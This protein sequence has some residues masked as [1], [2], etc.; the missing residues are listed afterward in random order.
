MTFIAVRTIDGST[1][2]FSD[3]ADREDSED[4]PK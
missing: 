1:P 2:P 3:R 4:Y